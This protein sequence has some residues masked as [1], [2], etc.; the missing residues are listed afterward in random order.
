MSKLTELILQSLHA[1]L[2]LWWLGGLVII[3]LLLRAYV[4]AR[5]N[6]AFS[7]MKAKSQIQLL[8]EGIG[9]HRPRPASQAQEPGA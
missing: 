8:L 3:F 6:P 5:K 9:Q 4:R 2:R 7:K 1:A